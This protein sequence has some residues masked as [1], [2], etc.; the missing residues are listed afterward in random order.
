MDKFEIR[1]GKKLSGRIGVEGAKNA[2]LPI[3][4]G[5]LLIPKGETTLHNI[6]PLRDIMTIKAVLEHL[7]AR[8]SFDTDARTMTIS[9]AELTGN[10][11]YY[12]PDAGTLFFTAD[13]GSV[14]R[15][16]WKTTGTGVSTVLLKDIKSGPS[17]YSP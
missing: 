5:A 7:G 3:I 2:A 10:R 8:V 16:L 12:M 11:L 4:A 9:A 6:P 17:S 13:D 14:G 1:G 15:E